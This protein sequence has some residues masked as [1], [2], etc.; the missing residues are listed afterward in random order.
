MSTAQNYVDQSP[1]RDVSGP[2][3]LSAVSA[4]QLLPKNQHFALELHVLASIA[5]TLP[6]RANARPI[7]ASM[8]RGM[9]KDPILLDPE[10]TGEF[11]LADPFCSE[12]ELVDMP[13]RFIAGS[14]NSAHL[15][16][17]SLIQA[18][19]KVTGSALP[20]TFVEHV[21]ELALALFGISEM[22]CARIGIERTLQAEVNLPAR[23]EVPTTDALKAM[24]RAVQYS[25]DSLPAGVLEL[26][27]PMCTSVGES[28]EIY[29]EEHF[30][31]LGTRPFHLSD[32]TLTISAPGEL[33]NALMCEV[34]RL[35]LKFGC[36]EELSYA[37]RTYLAERVAHVAQLGPLEVEPFVELENA[38]A[39]LF[40]SRI[41]GQRIVFVVT[42]DSFEG[43]SVDSPFGMWLST[44]ALE[45]IMESIDEGA[46]EPVVVLMAGSTTRGH[47]GFLPNVEGQHWL[48]LDP[49]N[50]EML[51]KFV[52]NNDP[53]EL[54]RFARALTMLEETTQV[55]SQSE[56]GQYG[57]Y[58]DNSDSFYLSD[59]EL[60]TTIMLAGD[61]G[62]SIRME[63]RRRLDE[64]LVPAAQGSLTAISLS[65]VD[66]APIYM[67]MGDSAPS[68]SVEFEHV[69]IWVRVSGEARN[70]MQSFLEGI[71]YWMWQVFSALPSTLST[72]E[73]RILVS[74]QSG[75]GVPLQVT[76]QAATQF[77]IVIR[78]DSAFEPLPKSNEFDRAVCEAILRDIARPLLPV[79]IDVA[80]LL[81]R[82]APSGDKKMF[83][84]G[85]GSLPELHD[86]RM[87]EHSR[88]I[89]KSV[90]SAVLDDLGH[91]LFDKSEM[92][93][94][95][96]TDDEAVPLLND[97]VALL[98]GRL[99]GLCAR[100]DT[101]VMLTR[102][103][104]QSEGLEVEGRLE[105]AR[106]LTRIACYGESH[107]PASAIRE[108]RSR[109]VE[110]SLAVRFLIEYLSAAPTGGTE[111]PSD[112]EHDTMCALAQE[113]TMMGMLSDARHYGLSEVTVSH[114]PSGRLGR[115]RDD[116]YATG[117]IT[118]S[119][120][121]IT[122]AL[123][124]EPDPDDDDD[125]W[126]FSFPE[127]RAFEAEFGFNVEEM[128]S[129]IVALYEEF[130]PVGTTGVVRTTGGAAISAVRERTGW[131]LERAGALV[132]LF[133][134]SEE[135]AFVLGPETAPWRF[136]R[137]RSYLRKP[138]VVVGDDPY[139]VLMWGKARLLAAVM[140]LVSLYR[141]GR[142]KASSKQMKALLGSVRQG[143]NNAFEKRVASR[144]RER[145]YGNVSE[146][147]RAIG[148]RKLI[149]NEDDLG[150]IDVLVVDA[151]SREILVVEAK[152]FE[153]ARTPI[154]MSREMAKLRDDAAPKNHRRAD[155]I[156]ANLDLF[157]TAE[158]PSRKP[159]AVKEILVTSRPST[160]SATGNGHET[161]VAIQDL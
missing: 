56:L 136:G 27:R 17:E 23:V 11:L 52:W 133:S 9:L 124:G 110:V 138:I 112:D 68:L 43:Y 121:S 51:L 153:T 25:I 74:I 159:W 42:T 156:R 8:L 60:P 151:E 48:M 89:A 129:G 118:H 14:S 135:A 69:F 90:V 78:P 115:S 98:F 91:Q 113:I 96:A 76:R 13:F 19:V 148:G 117:L 158:G 85:S 83:L 122:R 119:E 141:T 71:A 20:R 108:Q 92:P 77:S 116:R 134:M 5:V 130:D 22:M 50:V 155:W 3:L 97:A 106:R 88:L 143:K 54:V 160:A 30:D 100:F 12:I 55:V 105:L 33:A 93:V 109:R 161:V 37:Y 46:D 66:F 39:T 2:A 16:A 140:D 114:L 154:E 137:K 65:G 82:I 18:V 104:A 107:Y 47:M 149:E 125:P 44:G 80:G 28:I 99:K 53:W 86:P 70:Q 31:D 57:L 94:G 103:I 63:A 41:Q 147:V 64:H 73:L 79:S 75:L 111:P 144:F 87:A 45:P 1:W 127:V 36:E 145:G 131:D 123:R 81:Q 101:E 24:G 29:P 142:L 49:H 59:E 146:R 26:L 6:V 95:D 150:D 61:Y 132:Q 152:D 7:T 128:Q 157:D 62:L 40:T 126:E 38:G 10:G 120:L 58:K 102:L 139:G 34:Q 67:L 72:R 32:D 21:Y 15:K 35:A 4:L 84:V